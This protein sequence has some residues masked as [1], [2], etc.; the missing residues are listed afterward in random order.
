[1]WGGGEHSHGRCA[2][3]FASNYSKYK[4]KKRGEK[5]GAGVG[6]KKTDG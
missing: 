5:R 1:M 3:K 4:K 6:K 2:R